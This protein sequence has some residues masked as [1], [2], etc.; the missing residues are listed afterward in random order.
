VRFW[1]GVCCPADLRVM[2]GE[3]CGE[4]QG[5]A[6]EEQRRRQQKAHQSM[7]KW[8][9]ECPVDLSTRVEDAIRLLVAFDE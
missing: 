8:L 1:G 4:L 2:K 7:R 6:E 3:E 9:A 5:V